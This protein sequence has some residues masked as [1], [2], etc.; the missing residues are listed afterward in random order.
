MSNPRLSVTSVFYGAVINP[1]NLREYAILPRAV[2]ALDPSGNIAWIEHDVAPNDMQDVINHRLSETYVPAGNAAH[3]TITRLED[4]EFILPGFVDTHTHAPQVPNTGRGQ[5]Y[6]LLEW[7]DKMTFPMEARYQDILFAKRIYTEVV[8]R[9]IDCGTTTCC[10]YGSVHLEA[11]KTL[12]DIVL[13]FGQRA[14]VGKCCMDRECPDDVRDYSAGASV[15]ETK[16]LIAYIRSLK[17][18]LVQPVITPRFAISCTN[19][20]LRGLGDLAKLDSTL[21]IQTH[22]SENKGEIILTQALFP[23]CP[24]YTSVYDTYDLLGKRTILAHGVRLEDEELQLIKKKGAGISHCPT[25]NFNIRSGM[26]KV[27]EM[28]DRGIKVGL[29]TD[30]SG[31]YSPSILTAIQHASICSKMVAVQSEIDVDVGAP[32]RPGFANKQLPIATLLYLAT[33]GGASLCCMEDKIGSFAPG[34]SFDALIV[35]ARPETGNPSMWSLSDEFLE[36]C[37]TSRPRGGSEAKQ[38]LDALLERFLF[39]GDDRNILKVFV[40]GRCI[41]GKSSRS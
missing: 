19:E 24:T 29:G 35:S 41:G 20:L 3:V 25:S 26:A 32:E 38:A 16:E 8:R 30:V 22:I 37:S 17:S 4:G 11:T 12:A 33:L 31:G 40:Q 23:D 6:E 9:F 34:K 36:I 5:Q 2:I 39:C 15:E 21:A 13:D 27:G 7:L 1:Q 18:D 14:L 28:L 10:Y